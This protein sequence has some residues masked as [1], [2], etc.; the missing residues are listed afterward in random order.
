MFLVLA[1][2][3]EGREIASILAINGYEVLSVTGES[4]FCKIIENNTFQ[5]VIDTSRPFPESISSLAKDFCR[6][7]NIPYI[8]F[9]REEVELPENPM[10]FPVYTFEQAAEKATEFGT[11]IFM[12]TG[13]YNLE[14]F[15]RHPKLSGKRVVVR[16]LPDHKVI[17]KVQALGVAPRDI[18]AMQG[19]FS[20]EMN[21]ITFKMYNASVI[22]TKDSGRA[23]GIDTKIAAALDLKI[24]V[25]IVKR[26]KLL[27]KDGD[28]VHSYEQVLEKVEFLLNVP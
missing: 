20:K 14:L 28:I 23:G 22:V 17:A 11:T 1:G 19:P 16:I 13:S 18:V 27:E 21:R 6:R 15:L 4:G 26:P 8:R 7:Q 3:S 12:T 25:V 2:T 5:L 10:L 9:V 24:P